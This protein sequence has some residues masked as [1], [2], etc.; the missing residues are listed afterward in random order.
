MYTKN[1]NIKGKFFFFFNFI[2]SFFLGIQ[3]LGN[4]NGRIKGSSDVPAGHSAVLS[5]SLLTWFNLNRTKEI[6]ILKQ[7]LPGT[8]NFMVSYDHFLCAWDINLRL[9]ICKIL[10][11]PTKMRAAFSDET[12]KAIVKKKSWKKSKKKLK[13]SKEKDAWVCCPLIQWVGKLSVEKMTTNIT[14]RCQLHDQ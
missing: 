12:I 2:W 14:V 5:R 6:C 9:H 10:M 8:R 3:S 4:E 11:L 13:S 1:K 7:K